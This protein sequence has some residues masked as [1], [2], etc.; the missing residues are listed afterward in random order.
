MSVTLTHRLNRKSNL[1]WTS[2]SYTAAPVP[3]FA[4]DS[5]AKIF[6]GYYDNTSVAKRLAGLMQVKLTSK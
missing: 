2:Y 5:G 1:A 3:V 4:M 6:S